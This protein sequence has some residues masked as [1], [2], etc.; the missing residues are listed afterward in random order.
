MCNV[1]IITLHVEEKHLK[2]VGNSFIIHIK[3]KVKGTVKVRAMTGETRVIFHLLL[4][5]PDTS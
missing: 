2:E 4:A 5:H 3:Y 1:P